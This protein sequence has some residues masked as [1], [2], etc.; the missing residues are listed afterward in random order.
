MA[1]PNVPD[2]EISEVFPGVHVL[3]RLLPGFGIEV[4]STL[5]LGRSGAV[6]FD[7]MCSPHD[8]GPVVGIIRSEG[9]YGREENWKL[10]VV[11]S[12]GDWD[13]CL[14][15]AAFAQF[16][17]P[18]CDRC[19]VIAHE[20]AE[21]R[22]REEAQKELEE[23]R[24]TEPGLVKDA[25]II[26]PEMTFKEEMSVY[27]DGGFGPEGVD[28]EVFDNPNA[29]QNRVCDFVSGEIRL[30]HVPG[31]T[32]DSIVCYVPSR[33]LLIAGD[34]AEDPLPSLG[35]PEHLGKWVD[36]LETM[37]DR[38]ELVIPSH[39]KPQGPEL[40]RKNAKYL[41]G[42]RGKIVDLDLVLGQLNSEA[43]EFY[44]KTHRQ[45]I[46]CLSGSSTRD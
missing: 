24:K 25:A 7:T 3:T 23:L 31:H 2:S 41:R 38:V 45:N 11:Y 22:I 37:A 30:I 13:H 6:V 33:N 34:V 42:L 12:H 17:K 32:S 20:E 43:R 5:I 15:T 9:S 28:V 35:E 1:E 46:R 39:G 44:W 16:R 18:D 8:L 10:W 4:S 40:L 14:G 26:L 19:V 27:L 29:R 36:F 21:K